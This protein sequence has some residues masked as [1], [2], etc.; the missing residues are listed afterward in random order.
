[1]SRTRAHRWTRK[2]FSLFHC[3]RSLL[4][5]IVCV[6]SALSCWHFFVVKGDPQ[7]E[8]E[9]V[10]APPIR[11][12]LDH[13]IQR[14]P[15]KGRRGGKV[16]ALLDAKK[17]ACFSESCDL[18]RR[19]EPEADVRLLVGIVSEHPEDA[20]FRS[21][22]RKTWVEEANHVPGVNVTFFMPFSDDELAKEQ[23]VHRDIVFGDSS[24]AH[25][26][27]GYQMLHRLSH[28]T[29][30]QNIL[31]VGVR[32]VVNVRRV[33]AELDA[34]CTNPSCRDQRIWAG[35]V[36]NNR[37]IEDDGGRYKAATGLSKYL[38]YMSDGAY[39][40]SHSL[41]TALV[42]MHTRI[43]LKPLADEDAS[44]GLWL[45]PVP[46]QRIDLSNSFYTEPGCCLDWRQKPKVD[47][48]ARN[49][50]GHLPVLLTNL[51]APTNVDAYHR[52]FQ[53][54]KNER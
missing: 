15:Q 21:I 4:F 11:P 38:P 53:R 26:P 5:A 3:S 43:G 19:P 39:V 13:K 29:G 36:V 7:K 18:E 2:R 49:K 42:L 20:K 45:V 47:V 30:V 40:L 28:F 34:A 54:C 9:K 17:V 37:T 41:A 35:C 10:P 31:R 1:M 12:K 33:L 50:S 23:K 46:V 8:A 44:L 25:M 6:L 14:Q 24:N 27:V 51:K 52:A 48:C 22:A 16:D 32:S